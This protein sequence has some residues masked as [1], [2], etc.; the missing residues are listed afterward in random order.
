MWTG[1]KYRPVRV[2]TTSFLDAR[3][4][5]LKLGHHEFDLKKK[6]AM[7][8]GG[9]GV[10]RQGDGRD[11]PEAGGRRRTKYLFIERY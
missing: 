8:D 2:K 4:R 10:E 6:A 5:I 7:G 1:Q 3:K 11:T 9:T